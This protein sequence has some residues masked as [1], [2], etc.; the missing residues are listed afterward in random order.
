V[1]WPIPAIRSEDDRFWELWW[2][3]HLILINTCRIDPG[4]IEL[5]QE[6]WDELPSHVQEGFFK[7][8]LLPNGARLDGVG[9]LHGAYWLSLDYG[10]PEEIHDRDLYL[11]IKR[12]YARIK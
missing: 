2:N 5:T 10:D 9:Y 1:K 3:D 4:E 8:N 6:V 7:L 11:G 12:K